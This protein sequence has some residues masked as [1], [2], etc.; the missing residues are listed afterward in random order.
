MAQTP[1][2]E[3]IQN[4]QKYINKCDRKYNLQRLTNSFPNIQKWPI[5]VNIDNKISTDV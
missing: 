4:L 2:K 1:S 3:T 5:D